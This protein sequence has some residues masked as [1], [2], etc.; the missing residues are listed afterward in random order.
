MIDWQRFTIHDSRRI[1][2][3]FG[4]YRFLS[5]FHIA[6]VIF[7]GRKYK[8]TEHAYHAAKC[9]KPEDRLP[10]ADYAMTC[11]AAKRLGQQVQLRED[12]EQVKF[13]VML[14]LTVDKYS[15]HPELKNLLLATGSRYL[16]ETNSW[17]DLTWGVD[18]FSKKG[19]NR[20]GEIL[21]RVRALLQPPMDPSSSAL[22]HSSNSNIVQNFGE[23]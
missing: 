13:E 9:A 20:L 22:F 12:W 2:G 7:D 5:N 23:F 17:G 11:A 14:Q 6:D 21:M 1:C 16:E 15:R 18:A 19:L 8:S 4:D 10:F 3:F